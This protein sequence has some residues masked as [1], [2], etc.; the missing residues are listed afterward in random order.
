MDYQTKK[1]LK[2]VAGVFGKAGVVVGAFSLAVV[3]IPFKLNHHVVVRGA[4]EAMKSIDKWVK[5]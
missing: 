3:G 5:E 2:S 1:N 4:E